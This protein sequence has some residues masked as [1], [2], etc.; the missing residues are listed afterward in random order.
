MKA[1]RF[2]RPGARLDPETLISIRVLQCTVN[3]L[4]G[5]I[6]ALPSRDSGRL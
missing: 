1:P 6:L 5:R 4:Q 3:R 2:Q